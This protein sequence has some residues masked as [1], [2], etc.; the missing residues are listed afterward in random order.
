MTH[1][2]ESGIFDTTNRLFLHP[3]KIPAGG[4]HRHFQLV[5]IAGHAVNHVPDKLV[6][7]RTPIEHVENRS[8]GVLASKFVAAMLLGHFE[9]LVRVHLEKSDVEDLGVGVGRTIGVFRAGINAA[10]GANFSR[11]GVGLSLRVAG[12]RRRR[13]AISPTFPLCP[14]QS[15][16]IIDSSR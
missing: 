16:V 1:S 3:D 11:P 14:W 4:I 6:G 15:S 5:I 9:C 13:P 7:R 2:S 10:V 8:I 12:A